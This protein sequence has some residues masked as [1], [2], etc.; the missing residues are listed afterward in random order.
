ML[1][2]DALFSMFGGKAKVTI[3]PGSFVGLEGTWAMCDIANG[4]EVG[5]V[6]ART[7]TSYRP[8]I[9]ESVFV[10]AV[11]GDYFMLGPSLPKPPQGTV[12][13]VG[14]NVV[15]V[16]TDQGDV[17]ATVGVGTTL[18]TGQVVKLFWSGGAH[19]L[20]ALTAAPTP[21]T[22]P[23][24]PGSGTSKHVD[25]FT[26]VDAGSYSGGRWWQPQPWAS[27][28]T[29]GAWFMGR[30]IRDT[31][32]GAPVSRIQMFAA[33]AQQFGA[34]PNIGLHSHASKPGGSPTISGATPIAVRSGQWVDLP[35]SFGQAL[36][37]GSALGVGLSH[38]G[39][40]KFSSLAQDAR[41]GALRITSTY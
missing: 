37:N 5:R 16:S 9:N 39:F 8:E 15:T 12:T 1:T 41:S 36:S 7:T 28:S 11:D 20:A 40:N 24:A 2:A 27:D 6:P 35:V 18:S 19:V 13:S 34:N 21:P 38:G 10:A 3:W 17:T 22:P 33:V 31:L 25:E 14:T 30:K 32:Q 29:L 23:P 26:A 4:S